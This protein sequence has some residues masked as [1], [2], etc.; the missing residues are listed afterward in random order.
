MIKILFICHGNICRSAMSKFVMN[1]LIEKAGLSGEILTDSA[2]TSSE[3]LG[4]PL[5]P[6]AYAELQKHGINGD[7]HKA[8]RMK[9]DDYDKY[10]L[11]LGM[12]YENLY[13]M[14]RLWPKD[15]KRKI[16]LLMDYTDRPG[17]VADPWYTRDFGSTWRDVLEGCTML[18]EEIKNDN[19]LFPKN[20]GE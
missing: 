13:N 5:Y 20:G 16:H 7:G 8:R 19:Y 12:D 15:P 1:D 17:E 10:D 11:I 18:L 3:E 14:K 4:M 6:P 2:A 9:Q